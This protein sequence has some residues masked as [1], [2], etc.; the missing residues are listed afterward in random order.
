MRIIVQPRPG[1]RQRKY[2]SEPT[3]Q[4]EHYII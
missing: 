3:Q 2:F 4:H 1:R